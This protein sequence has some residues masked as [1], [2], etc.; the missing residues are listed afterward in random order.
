MF[1]AFRNFKHSVAWRIFAQTLLACIFIF[2]LAGFTVEHYIDAIFF[3]EQLKRDS[4][5]VNIIN[6]FVGT[7]ISREQLVNQIYALGSEPDVES[8]ILVADRDNPEIIAA[9]DRTLVGHRLDTLS[10][11]RREKLEQTLKSGK[12]SQYFSYEV[13]HETLTPIEFPASAT[14]PPSHG[15]LYLSINTI[16]A[17][18]NVNENIAR[19]V[20]VLAFAILSVMGIFYLLI[21]RAIFK[22]ILDLGT[23][24][25]KRASGDT[26]ARATVWF[27][28][29]IGTV[30]ASFNAMLEQLTQNDDERRTQER[31][32][33]GYAEQLEAKNLE[34]G[35]AR[36]AAE[37]ATTLKSEFLANMSHEIRTPI[38][39]VL[40]M[41]GLLLETPLN[42][43]Q[44]KYAETSLQSAESL[45][46]L[47]NDILD[48]SK[49]ESGKLKLELIAFDLPALINSVIDLLTPKAQAKNIDL[50]AFT[51]T[52]IPHYVMGDPGRIRQIISNLVDNAIKFTNQGYV[53]LILD[54]EPEANS[55][56]TTT[57][58]IS[59]KDTGVGIPEDAQTYIFDKFTQA[60]ASTTRKFGGTG[61]G[62][63]ICKQLAEMM[64]GT[65][66][67]ESKPGAGSVFWFTLRLKTAQASHVVYTAKKGKPAAT[68]NAD[69]TGKHILLCE[70]NDVNRFFAMEL[71]S[72]MGCRV[73]TAENG[74][75]AV[76]IMYDTHDIDLILMDC[77]MPEMDGFAATRAIREMQ[78]NGA[79]PHIPIIALTA[80]AMKGDRERCINAGMDDYIT[81][82]LRRDVLISTLARWIIDKEQF[83]TSAEEYATPAQP[84]GD[85]LPPVFDAAVANEVREYMGEKFSVIL[86]MYLNDAQK[87]LDIIKNVPSNLDD[88]SKIMRAAHSLKSSSAHI[89]A[90][91]TAQ[92]ASDLE[93][94]ARAALD[95]NTMIATNGAYNSLQESFHETR[96]AI[97]QWLAA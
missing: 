54:L 56:G 43:Q 68:A 21:R 25:R 93:T 73:T 55:D 41:T 57:L 62:L 12:P 36:L 34:I 35:M 76:D 28:D 31:Q 53:K 30:S 18:Y 3:D 49:I 8:I 67:L 19:F 59:V 97:D 64:G 79:T 1:A 15:A 9:T 60:D 90:L 39:G 40:G 48:F 71:L 10:A 75:I 63:A 14:T 42:P 23:I 33:M 58:K 47:I 78:K 20:C 91:R 84:T 82:P 6:M 4:T 22:P 29:E 50:L 7:E 44:R 13:R 46:V 77:Q 72:R 11:D 83:T 86:N 69:L 80:L 65:V 2:L 81:K 26:S 66:G 88:L 32:V 38:N 61:L 85:V 92:F 70:D 27:K 87:H 45:L 37:R 51:M 74:R 24:I 16:G 94:R 5:I 89:G 52:D 96:Q 95:R 17:Y